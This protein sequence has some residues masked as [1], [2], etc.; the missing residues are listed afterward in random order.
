MWFMASLCCNIKHICSQFCSTDAVNKTKTQH[1]Q[2]PKI[3]RPKKA[4]TVLHF[5][6]I[7]STSISVQVCRKCLCSKPKY[8]QFL[9][10]TEK[11]SVKLAKEAMG[12]VYYCNICEKNYCMGWLFTWKYSC[13]KLSYNRFIKKC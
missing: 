8:L 5:K 13:L 9:S 4:I 10:H 3:S 2:T 1:F 12:K 7:E 6:R 11:I